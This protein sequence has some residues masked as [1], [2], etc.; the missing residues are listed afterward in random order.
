MTGHLIGAAA[1][2]EALICVMVIQNGIIPPTI[3]LHHPDPE[4][5]L[6][7]VPN[8][9]RKANINIAL[10]TSFGFGG[11]NSVLV[12]KRFSEVSY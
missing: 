5:D 1:A 11:H 4:C 10:C 2:V 3:N 12:L 9:G 7:Y 8:V 6:D